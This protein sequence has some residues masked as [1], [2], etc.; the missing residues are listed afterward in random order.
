MIIVAGYLSQEDF[1]DFQFVISFNIVFSQMIVVLTLVITRIGCSFPSE[2]LGNHLRWLYQKGMPYLVTSFILLTVFFYLIDPWIVKL[3]NIHKT[4]SIAITGLAITF[5]LLMAYHLGFLQ[6]MESFR[7]IGLLFFMIGCLTLVFGLPIIWYNVSIL[8]VYSAQAAAIFITLLVMM[9]IVD[10]ALPKQPIPVANHSFSIPKFS[11]LMVLSVGAFFILYSMDI[12]AT[13]LFF[14]RMTA[15][16][17]ARLEIIGKISFVLST[18]IAMIIFPKAS[19]I[20]DQG[21]DPISY[22]TKGSLLY[23]GLS[24]LAMAPILL[25]SEEIFHSIFGMSLT[26]SPVLLPLIVA[27]KI[28]QSYI[29]I[30]INYES[31]VVD[32]WMVYI[33]G[34][35]VFLQIAMF[36]NYHN[37][38]M[39]VVIN[40]MVPSVLGSF[41]VLGHI[42]I[43]RKRSFTE[44]QQRM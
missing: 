25:F 14:N 3:A 41:V 38:L 24:V 8:Y 20:Y 28:F 23:F 9:V 34:G 7:T 18:S 1:G 39:Q 29:F 33:L 37:S 26:G 42:L 30:L 4:G 11:V 12:L 10:R 27:A 6:T 22:L 31:A 44:F 32:R 21:K 40:I 5:Y 13:K 36:L 35:L 16:Y 2:K 17:Y 19:K 15:G 43:K